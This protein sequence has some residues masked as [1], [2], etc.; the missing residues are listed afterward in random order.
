[1]KISF[2]GNCQANN[3]CKLYSSRVA[4]K[5][6]HTA[7]FFP[8]FTSISEHNKEILEQ[9][10]VIVAQLFDGPQKVNLIDLNFDRKIVYFP[11]MS[12]LFFW[13]TAGTPHP[14]NKTEQYLPNGPYDFNMGDKF[15]NRLIR[16]APSDEKQIQKI[17]TEYIESD[18]AKLYHADRIFELTIL[19]AKKK[20][21]VTGL[22]L[23][24][25]IKYNMQDMPM[26]KTVS[27]YYVPIF[28]K[29]AEHIFGNLGVKSSVVSELLDTLC[30]DT[31]P[32]LERPI[33]A[34]VAKFFGLKYVNSASRYKFW[35]GEMLSDED[36]VK[37]YIRYEW[38]ERLLAACV[39][40]E[41]RKSDF[42]P[43]ASREMAG[44]IEETM[45]VSP[46]SPR[47]D[48]A[49]SYLYHVLDRPLE[50]FLTYTRA[51]M[52]DRNDTHTIGH[53]SYLLSINGRQEEAICLLKDAVAVTPRAIQ[54]WYRL[55]GHLIKIGNIYEAR[56]CLDTAINIHQ[57]DEY[58]RRTHEMLIQHHLA[59]S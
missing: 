40:V 50:E 56:R 13:P 30:Q 8:S 15:L 45:R 22:N 24:D 57:H 19:A 23:A 58:L 32:S 42:G 46:G 55:I 6:G 38:N 7:L 43:E 14:C 33:H 17:V 16:N 29:I 44:L 53:Y 48:R 18:I 52:N 31:F 21:E 51:I 28:Y 54:L 11:T 10:D 49:L 36:Y 20:D 59:R 27:T 39:E 12:G 1:M 4:Q 35:T 37:R 25:Y 3:F 9:S 41:T 2:L 47:A 26:F 34:S 5:I